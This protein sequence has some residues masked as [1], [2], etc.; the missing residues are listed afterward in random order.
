MTLAPQNMKSDMCVKSLVRAGVFCVMGL[1]LMLGNAQA[2]QV[3]PR[4]VEVRT[5]M[6][7]AMVYADS[8]YL[9]RAIDQYFSIPLEAATLRLV[10]PNL[11]SW[12][13]SPIVATLDDEMTDS[14]RLTMN[15]QHHYRVE[16]VP[17]DAS[18]FLETPGDRMLLGETPLL[19]AVD[20][21][22]RGMLLVTKEGYERRR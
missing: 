22:I 16:S 12:S 4:V 21:P 14:L 9:G 13:M 10:P 1:M 11:D 17:Y 5:N 20:D 18:V 7:E 3:A 19:Y 2:Q 8:V 6:V 15:F